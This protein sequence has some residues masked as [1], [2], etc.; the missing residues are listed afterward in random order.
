MENIKQQGRPTVTF[1]SG[2]MTMKIVDHRL[3]LTGGKDFAGQPL[4]FDG[5]LDFFIVND[6]EAMIRLINSQGVIAC[7]HRTGRN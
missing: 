2:T 4:E 3:I 6:C 1:I 7:A 5:P